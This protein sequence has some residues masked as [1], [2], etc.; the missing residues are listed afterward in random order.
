MPDQARRGKAVLAGGPETSSRLIYAQG[1]VIVPQCYLT[2]CQNTSPNEIMIGPLGI[3]SWLDYSK[4]SQCGQYVEWYKMPRRLCE[5]LALSIAEWEWNKMAADCMETLCTAISFNWSQDVGDGHKTYWSFYHRRWLGINPSTPCGPGAHGRIKPVSQRQANVSFKW[6]Q[7]GQW[8]PAGK[9]TTLVIWASSID[10]LSETVQ[11]RP[12]I[13]HKWQWP[14]LCPHS[15]SVHH[16]DWHII[17][18]G[19]HRDKSLLI[20]QVIWA[21][22]SEDT[23]TFLHFSSSVKSDSLISIR[24]SYDDETVP[25]IHQY[26]ILDTHVF[27]AIS[28]YLT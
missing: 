10:M 19:W 27:V 11:H 14:L 3:A 18:L 9:C 28:T 13:I 5:D 21:T 7:S 22:N 23:L 2:Q 24:L 20:H 16:T 4:L 12:S 25:S 26:Q 17:Y 1:E 15:T 8:G 6:S